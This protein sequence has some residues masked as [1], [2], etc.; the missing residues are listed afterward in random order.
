MLGKAQHCVQSKQLA[1][2]AVQRACCLEWAEF[3]PQML[4][5]RPYRSGVPPQRS[6]NC[7][8]CPGSCQFTACGRLCAETSVMLQ[9]QM[10]QA[11]PPTALPI[12]GVHDQQSAVHVMG[13][14]CA[15]PGAPALSTGVQP[16]SPCRCVT[17]CSRPKS[18]HMPCTFPSARHAAGSRQPAYLMETAKT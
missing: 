18:R 5:A 11:H 10:R 4:L 9:V 2:S 3:W 8:S 7:H 1:L 6:Y 14:S 17:R 16:L 13:A 12:G 15:Y